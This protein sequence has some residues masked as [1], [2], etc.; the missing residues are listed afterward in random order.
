MDFEYTFKCQMSTLSSHE[1][2]MQAVLVLAMVGQC[3]V[4]TILLH[5]KQFC[6]FTLLILF[7]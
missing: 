6:L 7:I 1:L 4:D 2:E 5:F 3:L